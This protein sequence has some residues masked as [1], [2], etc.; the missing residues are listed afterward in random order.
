GRA[1]L[2]TK[3]TELCC[4]VTF[5][6]LAVGFTEE[7]WALLDPA[8]RALHKKVMEENYGNLA[9]LGKDSSSF[10]HYGDFRCIYLYL[11]ILSLCVI[12]LQAGAYFRTGTRRTQRKG[13]SAEV[14]CKEI[15][16]GHFSPGNRGCSFF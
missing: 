7:E 5:E 10:K 11:L 14:I 16:W 12:S 13:E 6:E 15:L 2:F 8:H 4:P 9:S 3:R 1:S